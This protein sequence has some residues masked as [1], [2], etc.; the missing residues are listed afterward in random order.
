MSCFR[1]LYRRKIIVMN[2]NKRFKSRQK[3]A[4]SLQI[5]LAMPVYGEYGAYFVICC[6]FIW[7]GL[8]SLSQ[9]TAV[10]G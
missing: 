7:Y 8:K 5:S 10:T 9:A 2:N 1:F 6:V 3:I 4:L